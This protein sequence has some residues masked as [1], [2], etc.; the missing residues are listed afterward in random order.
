MSIV[1]GARQ[2]LVQRTSASLST[3]VAK[4]AL[5]CCGVVAVRR[6]NTPSDTIERSVRERVDELVADRPSGGWRSS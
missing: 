5:N 2:R 6:T 1:D 3:H 4:N